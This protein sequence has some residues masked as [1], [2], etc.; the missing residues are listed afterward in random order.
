MAKYISVD[1]FINTTNG[2]A[3]D[4]DNTAGVQCV[5]GIKEFN[6]L[7]YGNAD[8]TCGNGWAYG[9]WTCYGNNGV[10]KYFD[11]FEYSQA[12]KGDWI[13]WNKG[14][15]QA[16]NSH[17]GMF[18]ERVGNN[19]VKSYSQNQAGIKAFNFCN[20]DEDGILGVLRPKIYLQDDFLPPRGYFTKGDSGDKI[21]LIDEF[22]ANQVK[23]NYYG[24]FTVACVKALQEKGKEEGLYDDEIDGN[25]GPKTQKLAE[26][27][28]FKY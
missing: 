7:V 24:S 28:G 20:V 16:P 23:G 12:K 17:V 19:K 5:D 22:L 26:H 9:L 18:I 2:K 4:V 15:K 14:S 21:E 1:E 10:E 3:Y 13:I 6:V 11:K 27:Y 25:W 8:F